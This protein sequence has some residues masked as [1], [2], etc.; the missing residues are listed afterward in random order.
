MSTL[1]TFTYEIVNKMCGT[2]RHLFVLFM[3]HLGEPTLEN[4][5]WIDLLKFESE[6]QHVTSTFVYKSRKTLTKKCLRTIHIN[7]QQ[8]G[9]KWNILLYPLQLSVADKV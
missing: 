8:D 2:E 9:L 5:S 6:L 3:D 4:S 7:Q 1:N